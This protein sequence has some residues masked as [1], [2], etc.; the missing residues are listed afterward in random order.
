M[1]WAVALILFALWFLVMVTSF[2][3]LGGIIGAVY[4]GTNENKDTEYS[5]SYTG[6]NV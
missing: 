1:L 5:I 6:K 2:R 4:D 3:N